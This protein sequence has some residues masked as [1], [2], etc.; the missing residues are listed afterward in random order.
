MMYD[1][2]SG[3]TFRPCH[4][5][6]AEN[7]RGAMLIATRNWQ[8]GDTIE[9]LFGVIGELSKTE[10]GAILR[11]DINDFSVMYSTR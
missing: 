6:N 4:R 10:E 11:K 8:K 1:V 2:S 9:Y 3:F 7:R 5:Y